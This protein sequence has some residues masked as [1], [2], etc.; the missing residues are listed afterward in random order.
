MGGRKQRMDHRWAKFKEW[1]A[2]DLDGNIEPDEEHYHDYLELLEEQ[3][4][5]PRLVILRIFG[6]LICRHL[7]TFGVNLM[8]GGGLRDHLHFFRFDPDFPRNRGAT[9]KG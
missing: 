8:Y 6:D 7:H 5:L 4:I 9:Q 2:W 1:V 3:A